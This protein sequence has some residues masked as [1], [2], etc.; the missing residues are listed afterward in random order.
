MPRYKLSYLN[1]SGAVIEARLFTAT[2][3]YDA[4]QAAKQMAARAQCAGFE[5]SGRNR[6][7]A[8]QLRDLAFEKS[9]PRRWPSS[10][11]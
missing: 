11:N 5:L 1:S 3:N 7:I 6:T 4:M 2:S 8:R 10:L 9:A